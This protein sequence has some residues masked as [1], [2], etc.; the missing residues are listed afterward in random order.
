M[1]EK[2]IKFLRIHQK[3]TNHSK[4]FAESIKNFWTFIGNGTPDQVGRDV[5]VGDE[6]W[7][8]DPGSPGCLAIS[9]ASDIQLSPALVTG[10]KS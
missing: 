3:F 2:N 8:D 6:V 7:R 9:F 5:S 4:V 1:M 10:D